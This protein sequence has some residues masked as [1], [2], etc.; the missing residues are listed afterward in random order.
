ME[1][2]LYFIKREILEGVQAYINNVNYHLEFTA[3]EYVNK[4]EINKYKAMLDKAEKVFSEVDKLKAKIDYED[5]K[6]RADWETI[7]GLKHFADLV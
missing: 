5:T 4:G 3:I 6:P 1:S 2:K 7:K